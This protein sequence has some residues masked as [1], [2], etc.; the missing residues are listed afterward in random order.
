[1]AVPGSLALLL[2][3]VVCTPAQSDTLHF[4]GIQIYLLQ[5]DLDQH[6]NHMLMEV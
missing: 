4:S 5:L 2:Y 1:V 3:M 6:H